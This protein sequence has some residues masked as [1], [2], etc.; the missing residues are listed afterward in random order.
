VE[1]SSVSVLVVGLERY[2]LPAGW[3]LPGAGLQAV[4]FVEW[5][6][7][8]G[9]D[10]A[11]VRLGCTWV[12]QA[13][14]ANAVEGLGV[15]LVEV[16]NQSLVGIIDDLMQ[17]GGDLLLVYWC[18]H[19]VAGT[20]LERRLLTADATEHDL[21]NRFV[22]DIQ[23]RFQSDLGAGFARQVFIIDAC[24]NLLEHH[25]GEQRALPSNRMQPLGVRTARQD[26]Y[27]STD[28]GQYATFDQAS[29]SAVYSTA[30]LDRL[31]E[32]GT[33]SF[34]PDFD[35]L[36]D[37]VE[38]DLAAGSFPRPVAWSVQVDGSRPRD[39]TFGGQARVVFGDRPRLAGS[40]VDR[41]ELDQLRAALDQGGTVAEICALSGMRGVGKSQLASAYAQACEVAG[42][43]LVAWVTA[44]GRDE[45]TRQL[46][47]LAVE[48]SA[49]TPDTP[50]G[51]AATALLN[52][53][54]SDTGSDRLIVFDNVEHFDDLAGLIP[55]GNTVRVILTSTRT[56]KIGTPIHVGG[57]TPTQS[58]TYLE[59]ATGITDPDG[60]TQVADAL[61]HLPVAL[62]QAAT[63]IRLTGTDYPGY[64]TLLHDHPLNIALQ[65]EDGDP[66]PEHVATAIATAIDTVLTSLPDDH[67][68]NTA[69][70]LLDAM[71]LLADTG[72]PRTWASHLGEDPITTQLTIGKLIDANILTPTAQPGTE[73][74]LH[75]LIATVLRQTHTPEQTTHAA[76]TATELI[77]AA[78]TVPD[79]TPYLEHRAVIATIATHL[80]ELTTQPHSTPLTH[81]PQLLQVALTTGYTANTLHD[82]YSA[83]ALAPYL[84][85]TEQVFG[86]EHPNTL[87]SRNNLAYAY[88]S[89]GDLGRAIPLYEQSLADMKRILGPDHPTTLTSRNNLAYAYKDAGNLDRAIQLYEQNLTDTERVLGPD[90]PDTFT[91][92]NNLA[93]AYKAAGSFDQVIPLF[94]QNLADMEHVLGADHPNTLTS[95][96]N[97]A[98]AY[99]SAGNLDQA[100]HLYERTLTDRQRVL[101]PDHPDTLSSRSSLASA[102]VTAENLD[103]GIPLLERTL[104]DRERVLG[105][106]HPSTLIS[107]N[108]L[109]SA[110]R[111]AGDFDRAIALHEQ[112][113]TDSER[114][115]GPDHPRTLASR[116]NLAVAHVHAGDFDQAISLFEQTLADRE[117]VLGPD[118]PDTISSRDDLAIARGADGDVGPST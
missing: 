45:I 101:G 15:R 68:R 89:A 2:G 39:R 44:T 87:A 72:I 53:V 93:G 76:D 57:Y 49:A 64:L 40:F 46:A 80:T 13:A 23:A 12:D 65:R 36:F 85:L 21:A 113:L 104:A 16:G 74:T 66:Y 59:E 111:D 4:R 78:A 51:Q 24:A 73:I 81:H 117:R 108:N 25:E 97:L 98:D 96:N 100:I 62:T 29:G 37:Q 19:G 110:Y 17:E 54:N 35:A 41:G 48:L 95:R 22:A 1:F 38:Q 107:R 103:T 94:E 70:K 90:H 42:W 5:A 77:D 33:G 116:N 60:A 102:F 82:P 99:M 26:F 118:H 88:G 34:P 86:P 69:R 91:G 52:W 83:I 18:G 6:I 31:T 114:V 11:R 112:N 10:P 75:R 43:E 20:Q 63:T 71:T 28:I 47:A 8:Q 32:L 55:R 109:A 7:G 27:F 58:I 9:V 14:G 79:D 67:A 84:D 61:G 105:S 92:R 30:I 3:D 50:P 115:L 106:D 56:G